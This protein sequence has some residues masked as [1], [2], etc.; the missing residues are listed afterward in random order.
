MFFV[1]TKYILNLTINFLIQNRTHFQYFNVIR[2]L[3]NHF[4]EAYDSRKLRAFDDL[5]SNEVIVDI[6]KG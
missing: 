6:D 5:I 4:V 2:I 1:K 3:D